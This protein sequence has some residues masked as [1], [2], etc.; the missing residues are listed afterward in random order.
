[1]D[2]ASQTNLYIALIVKRDLCG[3]MHMKFL[4]SQ[5]Y[6]LQGVRLAGKYCGEKNAKAKL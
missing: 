6:T 4:R 2:E 3:S 1:V 5:V